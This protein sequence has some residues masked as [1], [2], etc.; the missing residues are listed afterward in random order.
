MNGVL[1]NYAQCLKNNGET[2]LFWCTS[3]MN[4]IFVCD[5]GWVFSTSSALL[6]TRRIGN[7]MFM[8]KQEQAC[9]ITSSLQ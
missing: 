8:V 9:Q 7:F 2:Q 6:S 1:K 5:A 4:A 3:R